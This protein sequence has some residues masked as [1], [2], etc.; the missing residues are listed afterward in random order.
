MAVFALPI[1]SSP[2]HEVL[3]VS[4]CDRAVS[5]VR[6]ASFENWSCQVKN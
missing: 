1:I 5:D 3:R 4:Y 6:R 2:D